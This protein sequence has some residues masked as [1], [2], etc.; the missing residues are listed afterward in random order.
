MAPE[1]MELVILRVTIYLRSWIETGRIAKEI[2]GDLSE[3]ASAF[4]ADDSFEAIASALWLS[5]FDANYP[6]GLQG[7]EFQVGMNAYLRGVADGA[8]AAILATRRV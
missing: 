5:Y 3:L 8:A 6:D 1:E 2:R 7:H 4:N